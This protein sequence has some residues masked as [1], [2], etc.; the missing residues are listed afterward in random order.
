LPILITKAFSQNIP[1][2]VCDI[3][4]KDLSEYN[5]K[6]QPSLLVFETE[7]VVKIIE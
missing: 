3:D 1:L 2:K 5:I 4:L 6:S 7:N